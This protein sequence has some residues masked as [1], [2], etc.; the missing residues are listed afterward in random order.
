MMVGE[1]LPQGPCGRREGEHMFF[2]ACGHARGSHA[3]QVFASLHAS[4]FKL[5][6]TPGRSVSATSAN[7]MT[8]RVT[9]ASRWAACRRT[10]RARIFFPS[11]R[12]SAAPE[13]KC[14]CAYNGSGWL[15]MHIPFFPYLL[16][17][18]RVSGIATVLYVPVTVS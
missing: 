15:P 8:P 13:T 5:N 3:V 17:L 4:G 14:M 10:R 9:S 16:G 7:S 1:A 2:D 18:P 6:F 11:L 12:T